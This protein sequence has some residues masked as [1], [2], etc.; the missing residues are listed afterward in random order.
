LSIKTA[1]W[2]FEEARDV[3]RKIGLK[4][5]REW[6]KYLKSGKKSEYIPVSSF[7]TQYFSDCEFNIK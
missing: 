1:Y 6:R 2:S 5:N 3:I 7:Y 4:S